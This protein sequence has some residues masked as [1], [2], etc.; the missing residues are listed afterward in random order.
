[1][2]F[3]AL[4]AALISVPAMAHEELAALSAQA[5][6]YEARGQSRAGQIA[7]GQVVLNRTRDRRFPSDIC[8]V[9][10]QRRN[11]QCQFSWACHRRTHPVNTAEWGEARNNAMIVMTNIPD[12]TGGAIGSHCVP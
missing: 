3:I 11:N 7:V 1:M 10:Y 8:G 2:R 9:V 6:Y 5:I 12:I 4:A